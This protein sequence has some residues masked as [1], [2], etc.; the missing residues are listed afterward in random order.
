[1][2]NRVYRDT[3]LLSGYNI[4]FA[5][6]SSGSW[7]GSTNQNYF[8]GLYLKNS[9]SPSDVALFYQNGSPLDTLR[10][11]VVIDSIGK[12]FQCLSV[13][14]GPM[15][16]DHCTFASSSRYGV[17]E[18]PCGVGSFGDAWPPA[19]ALRFTNNLIYSL[20]QAGGGADAAISWQFSAPTNNLTSNNNLYYIPG[21]ANSRAIR[22]GINTGSVA[23]SAPGIGQPFYT[24]WHQDGNSKWGDPLL[25]NTSFTGFDAHP[26]IGSPAIGAATD[27]SDIGAYAYAGV[28]NTP[29][30]TVTDMSF[31]RTY[32]SSAILSWTAPGDNSFSGTVTSY[33]L[34]WSTS[35]ITV[36]RL[37]GDTT[38]PWFIQRAVICRAHAL[39]NLG[40]ASRTTPPSAPWTTSA[41][42]RPSNT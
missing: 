28:D 39:L 2:F 15:L 17:V 8:E 26:M 19:G 5:P 23:Y 29:P 1:M 34:R 6:S 7:P 20:R 42:G 18:Y 27:G 10:N 30:A 16:V 25:S 24:D 33:E 3:S 13:E 31:L 38:S 32:D 12:A 40:R 14:A 9:C 11:C 36:A 41:T 35:P 4:R 21:Q 37:K 22:Y